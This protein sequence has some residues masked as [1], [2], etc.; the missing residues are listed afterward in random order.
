MDPSDPI[1]TRVAGPEPLLAIEAAA[2]A[3][4]TH[5]AVAAATEVVANELAPWQRV[6]FISHTNA[7][8]EELVSRAAEAGGQVTAVTFDNFILR[9]LSPYAT[10]WDLPDPL[11]PPVGRNVDVPRWFAAARKKAVLLLEKTPALCRALVHRFPVVLADEHQDAAWDQHRVLMLM[12]RHGARVRVFGDGLQAI[13]TFSDD[14]PGWTTLTQEMPSVPLAGTWRWRTNPPLGSWIAEVRQSL[15]LGQPVDL[16]GAPSSVT[17]ANTGPSAAAAHSAVL[18]SLTGTGPVVVLVRSNADAYR[19]ASM[20]ALDLELFEGSNLTAADFFL[21]AVLEAEGDHHM[22]LEALLRLAAATGYWTAA[23]G[24]AGL[25]RAHESL[26][27]SGKSPP[28]ASTIPQERVSATLIENPNVRG[29]L[30][31]LRCFIAAAQDLGWT[32]HSPRALA[33]LRDLPTT[34]VTDDL[35]RAVF[36]AQCRM[37]DAPMPERC[38]STIHKAK[39]RQFPYAVLAGVGAGDFQAKPFDRSLLYVALSRPVERL[40]L[41]VDGR[42]SPLITPP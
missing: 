34:G 9:T 40:A 41:V 16:R 18:Q 13:M 7:A 28:T 6:L 30:G 26:V 21:N 24:A 39:G 25:R 35:H 4:K 37:A 19:L 36:E 33:V 17:V 3:G 14:V 15:L 42:P 31:A 38:V 32:L 22:I 11:K 5:L 29:A 2:G 12:Y 23:G 27:G 10:L 8:R 1:L 20:S